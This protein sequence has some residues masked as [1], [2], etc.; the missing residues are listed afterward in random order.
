MKKPCLFQ[1]SAVASLVVLV[2]L[3]AAAL[4]GDA[5]RPQ[6]IT[7]IGLLEKATS[8][9]VDSLVSGIPSSFEAQIYLRPAV[10][11]GAAWM[12]EDRLGAELREKGIQV[13]VSKVASP[14]AASAGSPADTSVLTDT[15]Q[16]APVKAEVVPMTPESTGKT[17]TLEYRI[18]ELGVNYTRAWRGLVI[19]R[20]KVERLA[21]VALHGR[22]V[23]DSSGALVWS[24]DGS[25]SAR[26]VVPASELSRLEGKG[27]TWQ[28]GTLPAGKLGG[29]VEPLVVAAI[30]AG[31]VYL[32]YSNKE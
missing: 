24:G 6:P 19:G 5:G 32:F 20:K 1:W 25:A 12:I 29:V 28:K 11:H 13:I 16:T 21:S 2:T 3:A 10:Q 23:E 27:E 9:A 15:L 17:M 8:L 4:A 31:L 18:T 7:N 22:L 30:V 14:A 26:D